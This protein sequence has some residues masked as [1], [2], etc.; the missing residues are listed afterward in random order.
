MEN[1]NTNNGLVSKIENLLAQKPIILQIL[2]FGCIGVLNTALDF[3]ILYALSRLFHVDVKDKIWYVN[4]FSFSFAAIQSYIW[5]RFWIFNAEETTKLFVNFFRLV[6][7]GILG[8]G[9]L[10]AVLFGADKGYGAPYYLLI[11]VVF[12]CLE[13]TFW[14]SFNLR[15]KGSTSTQVG[16]QFVE[17]VIVTGIGAFINSVVLNYGADT[18]VKAQ[19]GLNPGL[20]LY[21][22]KVGATLVSLVWNFLGYKLFVFR[23]RS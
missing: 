18:L 3:V 13:I 8:A 10:L 7:V 14:F 23:H 4:I 20:I 11:F 1:T 17:F 12:I 2:R 5:N 19:M 21:A 15:Q 6:L 16:V 9:S 22:A